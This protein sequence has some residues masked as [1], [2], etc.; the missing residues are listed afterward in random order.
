MS[1]DDIAI[2]VLSCK[3]CQLSKLRL[4]PVPG[5]GNPKAEIMFIGEAPGAK[6]DMMGKPFV[7]AAGKLLDTMINE[8]LGI[9]RKDVFITNVVKCRPPNNRDPLPEEIRACSTYLIS[10]IREIK[11]RVI[12][13]LGRH[14]T[15]FIFSSSGISFANITSVRG[16]FHQVKFYELEIKVFPTYH[17]AAALYNPSLREIIRQDFLKIKKEINSKSFTIDQFFDKDGSTN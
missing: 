10:Q 1:L 5:E 8:V 14:S 16:K 7:G 13:T 3:K 2:E 15:S 9:Q 11:P 17:P 4:N 12:V 6:E